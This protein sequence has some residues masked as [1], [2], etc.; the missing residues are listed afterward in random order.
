MSRLDHCTR[1]GNEESHHDAF[2][3]AAADTY[4]MRRLTRH[5]G[6]R[7]HQ[8]LGLTFVVLASTTS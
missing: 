7:D 4:P 3:R 5:E 6:P 1:A 8:L 2:K